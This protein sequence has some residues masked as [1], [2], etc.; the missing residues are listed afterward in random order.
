M[1]IWSELKNCGSTVGEP[2]P[3]WL[4]DLLKEIYALHEIAS[5]TPPTY[6]AKQF[7]FPRSKKR[8]VRDRWSKR[9]SNFV[10][11]STHEQS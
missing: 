7:R 10:I 11:V 2:S 3:E 9:I 5:R 4:L 6:I 1:S 8:R